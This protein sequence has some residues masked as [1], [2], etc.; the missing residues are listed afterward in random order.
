[1]ALF[2][3]DD[4]HDEGSTRWKRPRVKTTGR[5]RAGM[6]ERVGD[7]GLMGL[8]GILKDVPTPIPGVFTRRGRDIR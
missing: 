7:D 6:G 3:A 4:Y 1:M 2:R 8:S 5:K